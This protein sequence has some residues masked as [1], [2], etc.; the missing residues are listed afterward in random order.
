MIYC[1]VGVNNSVPSYM[2]LMC[3]WMPILLKQTLPVARRIGVSL[4]ATAS[5][6][7]NCTIRQMTIGT[8]WELL[9]QRCRV[10]CT[11][12]FPL[13][14]TKATR[15]CTWHLNWMSHHRS[16][17]CTYVIVTFVVFT[18]IWTQTKT[19]VHEL[20]CVSVIWKTNWSLLTLLEECTECINRNTATKKTLKHAWDVVA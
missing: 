6:A 11:A 1:W 12:C 5:I 2:S 9:Y 20:S 16:N 10:H 17:T 18:R 3:V 4:F 14:E 8:C 19:G 15:C 13:W 7:R